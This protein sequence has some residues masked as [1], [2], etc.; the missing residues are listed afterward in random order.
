M[1]RSRVTKFL[2]WA[3]GALSLMLGVLGIFLP[4]LPTTPFLLL[5]A[6]CFMRSSE[7]H[8][9]W[10][11]EHRYLGA[12]IRNYHEHR[13]ISRRALIWA[14]TT[15]WGTLGYAIFCV[16][17]QTWLRLFL[18]FIGTAVTIHLLRLKKAS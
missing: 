8:Y 10:L 1:S 7:R 2:L 3:G 4:L 15:L 13:A 6:A 18:V 14:L 16:A 12:Y 5:A 9:R 17:E 11:I